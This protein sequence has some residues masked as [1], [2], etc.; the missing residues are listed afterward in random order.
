[1]FASTEKGDLMKVHD[2]M[3]EEVRF[4]GPETNLA[5]A[6]AI[7]WENDCGVLPIVAEK[8]L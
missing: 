8:T 6:A 2:V 3:T 5:A 1:M 7:M 4:C